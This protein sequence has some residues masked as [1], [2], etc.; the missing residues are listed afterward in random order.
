[1]A[2]PSNFLGD[3]IAATQGGTVEPQQNAFG[4]IV[5]GLGSDPTQLPDL[6]PVQTRGMTA[7]DAGAAP[8]MRRSV[9]DMIGG[10]FGSTRDE[11]SLVSKIG[12]LA[13]VIATVG[14]AQPLYQPGIDARLARSNAAEDR[15]Y[16][17]DQRPLERR[18]LEQRIA[19]GDQGIE[20]GSLELQNAR[21]AQLEGVGAGL[22]QVFGSTGPEGLARAWPLVAQQFGLD[23]ERTQ[24]IGAAFAKDP[25]GTLN[26]L[27]PDPMVGKTG[28][29]AKEAQIYAL[30]SKRGTPVQ[31][32]AYLQSLTDPK[33]LTPYQQAQLD[34]A[35]QKFGFDQYKYANPQPSAGERK[36]SAQEAAKEAQ[37]EQATAGA[38]TFLD[39]LEATV[40]TLN[41]SGG[42]TNKNQS[43]GGAIGT[44]VRENIPMVERLK[45]PEGYAAREQLDGLLTQGVSALLPMLTGMAIGSKNM[46]AAKEM[47]NLKRAVLSAKSYEAAMEAIQRYR[48]N[49]QTRAAP[50][51]PALR[52]APAPRRPGTPAPRQTAKPPARGTVRQGYRFNGGDPADKRNWTKVQ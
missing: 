11:N 40:T 20:A 26:A 49:L 38:M 41:N 31:A 48:R 29:Q 50:A 13:D 34:L 35:R 51:A 27:F 12:G 23:A 45:N 14:G 3:L 44:F 1:M 9:L 46:D 18:L 33:A 37:R 25:E 8:R 5:S 32:A 7:A 30:L 21:N 28:S 47:E 4:R 24:Q 16:E 2:L 52:S 42:M 10:A 15:K 36:L 6:G 39:D 19:S 43:I 17:I 22:R